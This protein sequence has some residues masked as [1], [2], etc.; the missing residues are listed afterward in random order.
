MSD[1]CL[2]SLFQRILIQFRLLVCN[3][4]DLLLEAVCTDKIIKGRDIEPCALQIPR[5]LLVG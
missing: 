2:T 1:L 5:G 3:C 4:R